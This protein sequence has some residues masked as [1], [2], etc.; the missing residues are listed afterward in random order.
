MGFSIRDFEKKPI[1]Q[2]PCQR[3][4]MRHS[5]PIS[6]SIDLGL[7]LSHIPMLIYD[8]AYCIESLD[9]QVSSSIKIFEF[10]MYF[11]VCISLYVFHCF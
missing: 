8:L 7:G 3:I 2:M 6:P 1:L 5:N 10:H 11:I 4:I 9:I